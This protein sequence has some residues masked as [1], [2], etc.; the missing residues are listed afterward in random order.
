M[1]ELSIAIDLVEAI[2]DELPRLGG[3]HVRTVHLEIGA[4]S[5]VVPE[6]LE[7][8]FDVAAQGSPIAGARLNIERTAGRS[9]QLIALEV[10]D[11]ANCRGSEESSE[12]ERPPGSL[13]S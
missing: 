7:F 12:E 2:R 3:A 11:D 9:L 1:H 10:V 13:A 5:G 4:L 8:A 6:A